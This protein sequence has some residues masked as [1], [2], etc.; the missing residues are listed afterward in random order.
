MMDALAAHV[1]H[2]VSFTSHVNQKP[3]RSVQGVMQRALVGLQPSSD[4]FVDFLISD[5]ERW[6]VLMDILGNPDWAS[7]EIFATRASRA[8]YWDALEPLVGEETARFAKAELARIGQERK[9]P[10]AP[11]NSIAEA[12]AEQHFSVRD[13]FRSVRVN[14]VTV[15]CPGPPVRFEDSPGMIRVQAPAA[16]EHNAELLRSAGGDWFANGETLAV[17]P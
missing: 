15:R 1:R 12:A 2:D 10:A 13:A 11:V 3:T 5:D 7:S 4:G 17:S 6:Q 16:G 9:L 14:G 8:M